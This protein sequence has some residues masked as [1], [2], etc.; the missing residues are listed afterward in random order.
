MT[1][2]PRALGVLA[3]LLVVDLAAPLLAGL[4]AATHGDWTGADR[5][6][7]LD[8]TLVS[9]ASASVATMLVTLTGVPLGYLLARRSGP[10]WSALGLLVQLPLALPPLSSGVLLLFLLGDAGPFGRALGGAVTDSF[11]GIVLAETFVASPFAV[12]AARSAFAAVDP[13]LEGV[14]ATLG[15]APGAVFR[16]VSV[17][18]AARAIAAGLMLAWLRAFGE[19]G[20]TTM[21]A[22]HPYTLP[23][24]TSVAFG[25]A[26]L[27]AMLPVIAPTLGAALLVTAA[28]ALLGRV[29]SS[30]VRA[31]RDDAP[32]APVR[33]AARPERPPA[34]ATRLE[35]DAR[36]EAG[37]FRLR[38]DWDTEAR[39]LAILG[40]SGSGKSLTLRLLA[41]LADDRRSGVR[42][43]GE[44]LDG[45]PP[46]RRR[47]GYVPQDYGLLPHRTV[48]RQIRLAPDHDP[49]AAARWSARL[50]L[51]ALAGRRPDAISRGQAQRVALARALARTGT[52]LLLLDEPFA[53]LDTPLRAR[54][55]RA[56]REMQDELGLTTILVTHDPDDAAMLADEVLLLDDGRVLQH[57]TVEHVFR[58]PVN[59]TAAAILGADLIG[60]GVIAPDGRLD[61]GAGARLDAGDALPPPG[62]AIGWSVDPARIRFV[63]EGQ[64]VAAT[65]VSREARALTLELGDAL[66]EMAADSDAPDPGPVGVRIAP[67][68]LQVWPRQ[69]GP[70]PHPGDTR[71][72]PIP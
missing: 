72:A 14:A 55:R 31:T 11:A 50:G 13:T 57:G 40:P 12:I 41:G 42:L 67:E 66:L 60:C 2:P 58:R 6:A 37:A 5:P 8:A 27:P 38:V 32:P 56:L 45:V 7:L 10:A 54:L 34:R 33:R 28:A 23:V 46:H 51:D 24:Y 29:R 62:T 47:I 9:L 26:G 1:R 18:L 69:P 15:L 35:V 52:R 25:E 68:A 4:G 21:V 44:R 70:S 22:Y 3:A 30:G 49:D 39:R 71:A 59:E 20:A 17:P 43:G 65:V 16:R 36:V 63:P 64:G 48:A 53:A 19:F 61:L